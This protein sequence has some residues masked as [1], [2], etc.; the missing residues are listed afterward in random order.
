MTS[1]SAPNEQRAPKRDLVILAGI[2]V[3]GLLLRVVMLGEFG[4]W[5]DEA[6]AVFTA[7]APF[8]GGIIEVLAGDVHAPLYFVLLH[9]WEALVGRSEFGVRFLSALLGIAAIP[10]LYATGRA[11]YDRYVG[12]AAAWIG[13]ILPLHVICSRTTR[14]YSLLPLMALLSMLAL[15]RALARKGIG[16]WIAYAL[17]GAATLCSHYWGALWIGA[18]AAASLGHL[19]LDRRERTDWVRWLGAHLAIALLFAPWLPTFAGQ[20]RI[21][22]SVMGPWLAQQS[23]LANVLRLFNELTALAWPR[24]LPILWI[25]LIALGAFV[26]RLGLGDEEEDPALSV[27]Y[28]FQL[29]HMMAT[30]GLLLPMLLGSIVGARSEGLVPSYV[31]MAVYPALCLVL[32]RGIVSL[33]HRALVLGGL[34][35]LSILWLRADAGF[36]G[37]PI[38]AMREVAQSV[39]AQATAGDVIVVAPDYLAP[40]FSYYYEGPAAQAAFPWLH[41]RVEAMDWIGWAERRSDAEAA[42]PAMLAHIENE[43]APTGIVWLVAPLNAYP[44]DPF[45][46]QMRALEDALAR[47]YALVQRDESHRGV[48]ETADIS[49]YARK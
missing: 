10:L 42:V 41:R 1:E 37:G 36:Y 3:V 18:M 30:L 47:R 48:V 16:A 49:Q 8:P 39:E 13:A 26:Y 35:L 2:V 14:M 5:R 9:F 38:S 31:T 6:E 17:A 19:I 33:R 40:T 34:A 27:S 25:G 21:Q 12:L 15:H 7:A 28:P 11:L 32:A 4:L 29:G 44:N 22:E 23:T 20:L 46:E 45:F 24:G 43:L